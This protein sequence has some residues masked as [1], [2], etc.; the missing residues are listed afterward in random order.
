MV[1]GEDIQG[2]CPHPAGSVSRNLTDPA[3]PSRDRHRALQ[4]PVHA[5]ILFPSAP[6]L[7]PPASSPVVL[8]TVAFQA[9]SCAPASRAE[10]PHPWHTH[11]SNSPTL[12]EA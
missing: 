5:G 1:W 6:S 7:P 4:P 2:G 3:E 11:N 12:P 8:L 10:Y 9:H